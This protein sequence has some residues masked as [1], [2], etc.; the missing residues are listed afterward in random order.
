MTKTP[1]R[2]RVGRSARKVRATVSGITWSSAAAVPGAELSA[3]ADKQLRRE[4][5]TIE[6]AQMRARAS[7]ANYYLG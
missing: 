2:K 3:R 5:R 6:A 4:L 1:T 7:A